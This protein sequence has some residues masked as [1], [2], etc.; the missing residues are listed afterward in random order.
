MAHEYR[1]AFGKS[2]FAHTFRTHEIAAD[3]LDK[4]EALD[5]INGARPRDGERRLILRGVTPVEIRFAVLGQ[6]IAADLVVDQPG[7]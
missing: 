7:V 3:Y 2:V 6:W 4:S 1:V 5:L